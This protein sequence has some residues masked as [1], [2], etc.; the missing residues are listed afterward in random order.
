[1]SNNKN[2]INEKINC[3][4]NED[5]N[6]KNKIKIIMKTTIIIQAIITKKK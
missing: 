6:N 3:K 4:N 1:M 5:N 2:N